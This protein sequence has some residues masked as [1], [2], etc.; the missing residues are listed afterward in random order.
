MA[1]IQHSMLTTSNFRD[2][3]YTYHEFSRFLERRDL[4][5]S[6]LR[7]RDGKAQNHKSR[8]CGND[9]SDA[10]HA[11][12]ETQWQIAAHTCGMYQNPRCN[13]QDAENWLSV[14]GWIGIMNPCE[15][16]LYYPICMERRGIC[17]EYKTLAQVRKE[18]EQLNEN[19]KVTSTVSTNGHEA[20]PQ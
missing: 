8:T 1:K 2:T 4:V 10:R 12:S 3:F 9:Q 20:S 15:D 19:Q 18:I 7:R 17:T 5:V 14:F 13:R 16:C 6:E 11:I